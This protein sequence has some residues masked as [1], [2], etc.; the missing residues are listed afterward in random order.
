MQTLKFTI[1]DRL[2]IEIAG[3]DPLEIWPAAA[4][5]LS[6][7]TACPQCNAGLVLEY[8]TPQS[9]KYYVLKCT[10]PLRHAVNLGQKQDDRS[11]YYDRTKPWEQFRPGLDNYQELEATAANGS[12]TPPAT[13]PAEHANAPNSK[14]GE[15]INRIQ[16]RFKLCEEKGIE[17]RSK[18][19]LE[20]LGKF[21]DDQLQNAADYL[22][23]QLDDDIPF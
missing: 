16:S 5:W 10:G 15:L 4:F 18:V 12:T 17:G 2:Q 13:Q 21:T 9:Y 11:L 1:G 22:Q 6:L 23:K 8:K 3:N 14:R 19:K 7:P 20:L